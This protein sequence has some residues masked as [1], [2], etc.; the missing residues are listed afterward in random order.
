MKEITKNYLMVN[1]K[2]FH[3]PGPHAASRR[4]FIDLNLAPLHAARSILTSQ[5][6]FHTL[7]WTAHPSRENNPNNFSQNSGLFL[8]TVAFK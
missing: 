5:L 7:P 6:G 3:L 2:A 4:T 1:E 8:L